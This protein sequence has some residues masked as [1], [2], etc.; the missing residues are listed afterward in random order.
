MLTLLFALCLSQSSL[1]ASTFP[2]DDSF[3]CPHPDPRSIR[4]ITWSCI[5]TI[6][7]CTW[8]SVHPNIPAPGQ[9]GWLILQRVE[10][11]LWTAFAPEIM[12][13]WAIKQWRGARTVAQT[14]K[15]RGWTVTHGH[16]LQMGGFM[17]YED[18][19]PQGVLSLTLLNS[20][21]EEGCIEF[22]T[23]T[24]EEILDRS[25]SDALAK[26]VAVGQLLWFVVQ[27]VA[28]LSCHLPIAELELITLSFCVFTAFLYF[29]WWEKPLNV[30]TTV[31]VNIL[32]PTNP[33]SSSSFQTEF[34]KSSVTYE[35]GK[36]SK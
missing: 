30:Q 27:A 35:N 33:L 5:A 36:S 20:L 3:Q 26:C 22:P 31:P 8:I 28:R 9:K 1:A 16:F 25:K 19:K 14:Y 4:D 18:G 7:A 24:R 11:M 2:R 6:F 21:L 15:K 23:I 32:R 13:F 17:L 29:F 10:Y 34:G 12:L